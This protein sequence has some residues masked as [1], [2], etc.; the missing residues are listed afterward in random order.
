MIR[1]LLTLFAPEQL[2]G[3]YLIPTTVVSI[4]IEHNKLVATV[5]LLKGTQVFIQKIITEPLEETKTTLSL[6]ITQALTA[7]IKKVGHYDKVITCL[8]SSLVMFKPFSF[9]FIDPDK[10]KMVLGYELE[11]QLPFSTQDA[12]IDF[13]ITQE[14][15]DPI[16]ADVIIA[17]AQKKLIEEFLKPF[18]DAGIAV[19]NLSVDTIGLYNLIMRKK[20]TISLANTVIID[21][22]HD[23]TKLLFFTHNQLRYIRTLRS[24]LTVKTDELW[25][26]LNF[27]LQS[28]INEQAAQEPLKIILIDA[29]Q[30]TQLAA[31][32][33][34]IELPSE[35]ITLEKLLQDKINTQGLVKVESLNSLAIAIPFEKGH[36]FSL[37]ETITPE[38][39]R[40][41]DYQIITALFFSISTVLLLGTHTFLQIRKL[42]SELTASQTEVMSIIKENFPTI[43]AR[44][45]QDALNFAAK[46]V[47]NEGKIWS[48]FASETRKSFLEYFYDLSTK[49]DRETLGLNLK[50][51]LINKN[52]ITLEGN[53]RSFE[54]VEQF[55]AQ[56]KETKLFSNVPDLQKVEFSVVLPLDSQGVL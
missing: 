48:S 43:T 16:K 28:C 36:N 21:L 35:I 50:K 4:V 25:P 27:T 3:N 54:A 11:G 29:H 51:M 17:A 6:K 34:N 13:I 19:A 56:L 18:H 40:L 44:N 42:S 33:G 26:A 7:L 8:P 24:G 49:I 2:Q 32:Q 46:E 1:N 45:R 22:Q 53:V 37:Q 5:V 55:E 39:K 47:Q 23:T 12:C 52:T 20:E 9:P 30:G 14:H 41:I 10:I 15:I 31:I 38:Q